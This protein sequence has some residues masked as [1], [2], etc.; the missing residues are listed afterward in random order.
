MKHLGM[1]P[2]WDQDEATFT[3]E[4]FREAYIN[5]TTNGHNTI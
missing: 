4:V 2:R 5:V 3:Y 1:A